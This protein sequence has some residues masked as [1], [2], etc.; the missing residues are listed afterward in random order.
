VPSHDPKPGEWAEVHQLKRIAEELK[1]A[2]KHL[3]CICE[4]LQP[5]KAQS[6]KV[7]IT[8]NKEN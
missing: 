1:K 3:E 7:T 6:L 2:N 5:P 8:P 4:A